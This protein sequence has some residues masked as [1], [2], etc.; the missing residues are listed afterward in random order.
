MDAYN[1][2]ANTDTIFTVEK[3]LRLRGEAVKISST[4]LVQAFIILK[5]S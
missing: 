3:Y 5:L 1:S 4:P 2:Y